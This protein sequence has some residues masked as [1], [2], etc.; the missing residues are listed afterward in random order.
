M[1][2]S[3]TASVTELPESRVRVDAHVSSEE[4]QR[5]LE[6]KAR[7]LGRQLKMPGF[8]K[9]K[10]P[11]P[12]VLRRIGR[13]AVLDQTVRDALGRWYVDA[14]EAAGIA[15]IG[16][17]DLDLGDLP[18]EGEGLDFTI[19]I[20]VR[21]VARLGEY[22][23]VS[24]PRRAPAADEQEVERELTELRERM[25]RLEAVEREASSGDFV[26]MD[27]LGRLDGEAF[28]GGEGRDELLELGSGRLVPGF[29]DGLVGVRGGETRTV[30]VTFP[31]DYGA[32][33]LAGREVEFEV[34]VKEVKAKRVPELDDDLAS[35]A[36]GLDT[37]AE[38]REDIR[39]RLVEADEARVRSEFR[40]AALDAVTEQA[41]LDVPDALVAA[42]ATEL[43]ERMM[44]SLS[45]QGISK[46]VYLK[47]SGKTEQ[48]LLDEVAPDAER[49]LRREAVLA[50]VV[51]AEGIEPTEEDLLEAVTATAQ[52][53]GSEP[54]AV[55]QALRKAGRLDSIREDLAARQALD[56][57]AEHAVPVEAEAVAAAEKLWTPGSE[58][59]QT[60]SPQG[61]G[62]L[63]TPDS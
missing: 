30:K 62:G 40:E 47:I 33:Q 11:A 29:E 3:V 31:T 42:R 46:E 60:G 4:V 36:A 44:H 21:P 54:E 17:P 34:T 25:A 32:E 45:H 50:A 13:D 57:I 58:P 8:R 37:L 10:V 19:E 53:D 23:G 49:A 9:G 61:R 28:A 6:E 43:W 38:L 56:L 20:G 52:R 18:G 12:V 5:R 48:E 26:V 55:L 27:Y 14:I 15:P 7:A 16:D 2:P 59:G 51:A 63:W 39:T 22:R 24:V 1:A 35:E 41:E